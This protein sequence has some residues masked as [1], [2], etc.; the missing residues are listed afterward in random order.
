M[1]RVSITTGTTGGSTKR[2]ATHYGPRLHEDV[3]PGKHSV[4]QGKEVLEFVFAYDDL[5]TYSTDELVQKLPANSRVLSA[6]LKVI[7]PF[8]GGTSY[9]IGLYESDG[10]EI[11]ADGI[12]AAVLLAA[13]DAVGET[14][15]CDGA[16]VGNTAGIGT[17][18]GQVVIAAT[19]TFT[20]GKAMLYV[21]YER[22]FDRAELND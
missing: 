3:A 22:L 19:G 20:A 5:P 2:A 8:A 1:A 21:E 18:A 13:I 14:V 17:A 16:L 12:D 6:T 11:D 10:T 7:T 15:D 4:D 9:D